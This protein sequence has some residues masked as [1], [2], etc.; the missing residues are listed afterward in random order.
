MSADRLDQTICDAIAAGVLPGDARR[1]QQDIRPWPVVLLTA[2]G[3]WLAAIPLLI[4][5]ARLVGDA[6]LRG[7]GTYVIGT[8]LLAGAVV[9]LRSLTL[10]LFVEQ[11]A[12]PALMVGASL[13]GYALFRDLPQRGAAMA[14]AVL[15]AAVVWGV[16]KPWLRVLLGSGIAGL[17]GLAVAPIHLSIFG[18]SEWPSVWLALHVLVV[19]A[20]AGAWMQCSLFN[21]GPQA[22][23]AAAWESLSVGWLLV[24]LVGLA[25]WAGMTFLVGASLGGG[26]QVA[27]ELAREL[28]PKSSLAMEGM[29]TMRMVSLALAIAAAAWLAY[30]WPRVRNT[31]CVA[32]ALVCVVLAACMPSLGAVLLVMAYCAAAG[33]W[34]VASAAG[35]AMAWI[36]GAFYYQL[37]WSLADKALLLAGAG[38][39]LAALAWWAARS[40]NAWGSTA[41]GGAGRV[42]FGKTQ[43]SLVFAA[44]LVLLVVNGGIWQKE[45]LIAHGKPLFVPLLPVDP[46]S[47]MQGDYMA[48]RFALP[49]DLSLADAHLQAGQ[50]PHLVARR[51][52]RGIATALRS[53]SGTPL[54]SDEL[55][56]E[57]A[58]KNGGWMLVTD[59]WYFKEGEA[60]RWAP[61]KYGEFRV[62]PDGRALLVGLRGLNL[63]VL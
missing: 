5:V 14:S 18:R 16:P 21:S 61:A 38:A 23:V 41:K 2:L 60:A 3:A 24:A 9:L 39:L 8:L 13:L 44:V 27:G 33:R 40:T 59:A 7:A 34:R 12:V 32:V 43:A 20:L 47:L 50:R 51:D 63:G 4:V 56:I 54:S 25:F 46:R 48:L 30:C 10:P 28:T 17:A 22:R 57:L 6:A 11:L 35:V 29:Q 53:D 55:R 19:M 26:G 1:P 49:N 45:D 36:I 52:A 15:A 37:S 58:P 42:V 31:W 62:S